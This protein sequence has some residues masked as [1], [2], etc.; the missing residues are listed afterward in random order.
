[1][2]MDRHTL[3][4][5]LLL[6]GWTSRERRMIVAV[7]AMMLLFALWQISGWPEGHRE[8]IS[9]LSF[10]PV[11]AAAI[12]G[13]WGAS[14]R[15]RSSRRLRSAWRCIA[16]AAAFYM[17]GDLTWMGY[18]LSGSKPYPSAADAMYLLFYPLMLCGL[19]RFPTARRTWGEWVRLGL[20][21]SVMALGASAVVL[22]VYLGPTLLQSGPDLLQA[23][24]SIAYPVGDLILLVGLASM[25]LRGDASN[26][27]VLRLLACGLLCF[28]AADLVFGYLSLHS[29]YVAGNPNDAGWMLAMAMFAIAGSAQAPVDGDERI[30]T[31]RRLRAASWAPYAAVLVSFGVLIVSQTDQPWLPDLLLMLATCMIALLV[32]VRQVLAGRDLAR[33]QAELSYQSLHDG[34]TGLPNRLLV[35]DRAGRMLARA[36]RSATMAAAL[37]VDLDGFKHVNDTYGHAAGDEL[38]RVVAERLVEAVR[39]ADTVGRL[40]GDEFL[41]LADSFGYDAGPEIVAERLRDIVALPIELE[42]AHGR[43]IW[44]T[45]SIGIALGQQEDPEELL[46]NADIALYRAKAAGKNR[47][48]VFESSMETAMQESLTLEMDLAEALAERQLF[49]MYQPIFD[50]RTERPTAV[51]ALLRWRHPTRGV[52]SPAVFIPLAEQSGLI[53]QIGRWVLQTA[54]DQVAAWRSRGIDLGV[55]VNV[56]AIQ[57]DQ[58]DFVRETAEML[59]ET[60]IEPSRLRLEITESTLMSDP[61]GARDR[62]TALKD[63][64]VQIAIDD[65][66]TGYSSLAYL[67]RFPIDALKIDRSFVA[68]LASSGESKAL[69]RMLVQ[70]GKTLGLQLVGE[71]IEDA[72]QL[73]ELQQQECDLGQGFLFARPLD[74]DAIPGFFDSAEPATAAA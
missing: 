57:L 12:L 40:G 13:A 36:R 20:D 26:R 34:L 74:P 45:V 9:D 44:L 39:E 64:G 32:S 67:S 49:L 55:S 60:G 66:G 18:A 23:A 47:W 30:G 53:V 43:T 1:M 63:L 17:L 46:R 52:I 21:L 33:T 27:R 14:R 25:L 62:L 71:G 38:L 8:L 24:D 48:A 41:V 19:L 65:F 61:D 42:H 68:G 58:A 37:Y 11:S 56:S 35:I 28:V 7:G 22:Y 4:Q 70:L 54:C 31:P 16:A 72:G 73:R 50:L 6:R 69:I 29:T 5:R 10:I 51:E 59:A 2:F 15:C 3:A